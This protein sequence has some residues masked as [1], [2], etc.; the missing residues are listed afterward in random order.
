MFIG[1]MSLKAELKSRN[2]VKVLKYGDSNEVQNPGDLIFIF[3]A[4]NHSNG[5]GAVSEITLYLL[6]KDMGL[7]TDYVTT[8]RDLYKVN[9]YWL[10]SPVT[11]TIS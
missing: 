10:N 11:R 4:D 9:E 5:S 2:R 6:G 1:R 8:A 7:I 3:S